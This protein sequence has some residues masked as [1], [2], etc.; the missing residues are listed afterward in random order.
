MPKG[1][2][3]TGDAIANGIMPNLGSTMGFSN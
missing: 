1:V 2:Q 3:A